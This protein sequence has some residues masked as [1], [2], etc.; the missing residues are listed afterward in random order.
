[1][2]LSKMRSI[3]SEKEVLELRNMLTRNIMNTRRISGNKRTELKRSEEC[4]STITPK[5]S[6]RNNRS[7]IY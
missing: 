5:T 2:N 7:G 4:P 1:M 6:K 3:T